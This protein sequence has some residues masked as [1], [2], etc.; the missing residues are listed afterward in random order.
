M[1]TSVQMDL[2]HRVG[3]FLQLAAA[4]HNNGQQNATNPMKFESQQNN[5]N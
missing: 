5:A 3:I 2:R 1:H 4:Q